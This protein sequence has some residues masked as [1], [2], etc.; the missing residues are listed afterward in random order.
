M[1]ALF[2]LTTAH[3]IACTVY[4]LFN[5]QVLYGDIGTRHYEGQCRERER[6]ALQCKAAKLDSGWSPG[7]PR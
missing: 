1:Q 4:S 6:R 5:K 3:K 2:H 7:P